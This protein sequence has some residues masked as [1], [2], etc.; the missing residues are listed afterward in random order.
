VTPRSKTLLTVALVAIP[1]F[2]LG[3]GTPLGAPLWR[4]AWPFH[5]GDLHVTWQLPFFMAV[6]AI[7]SVATGLGV[8]F[9][10]HGRNVARR[11]A[12]GAR[13]GLVVAAVAW[14]L[15]NW[16][17]HDSL[18]ITNGMDATGLLIID[19]AFHVSLIACAAVV[20]W[21]LVSPASR[22]GTASTNPASVARRSA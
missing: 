10:I 22:P 15:G 19:F 8:A 7:E 14:L 20:A 3:A 1:T 13:P 18:H 4:A 16:W 9:A 17:V 21:A 2:L 5:E 6:G 12:P 11:F